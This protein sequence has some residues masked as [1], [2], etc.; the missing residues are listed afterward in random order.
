MFTQL[1]VYT[2]YTHHQWT[3]I[4]Y[5]QSVSANTPSHSA[6]NMTHAALRLMA[7]PAVLLLDVCV[8]C[9][10]TVRGCHL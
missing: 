4:L 5:S 7:W 9:V 10:D 3:H 8:V 1:L 6:S 2:V